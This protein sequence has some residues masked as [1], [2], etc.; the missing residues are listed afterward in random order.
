M[1]QP[2][3]FQKLPLTK[4]QTKIP[5][6]RYPMSVRKILTVQKMKKRFALRLIELEQLALKLAIKLSIILLKT[7]K[8][9][10]F[11]SV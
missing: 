6:K 4:V 8:K 9:C 10:S 7:P 2:L 1:I 11:L 3:T 5:F